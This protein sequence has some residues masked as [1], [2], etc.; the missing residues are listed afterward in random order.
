MP[1]RRRI[2]WSF[3]A[4]CALWLTGCDGGYFFHLAVGQLTRSVRVMPIADDTKNVVKVRIRVYLR[5]GEEQGAFLKPK[6]SI[7]ATVYNSEFAF[8]PA[9]DQAW[10]DEANAKKN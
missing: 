5:T 8:D 4:A 9:K 2:S 3:T 7:T 6:M 10:G 1:L